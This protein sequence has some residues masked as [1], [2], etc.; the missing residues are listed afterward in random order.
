MKFTVGSKRAVRSGVVAC[1]LARGASVLAAAPA[2]AVCTNPYLSVNTA[3]QGSAKVSGNC[4]GTSQIRVRKDW[5]YTD[6]TNSTVGTTRG[7]FINRASQ[8]STVYLPSGRF[9]KVNLIET[10]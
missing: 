10:A 3:A 9:H 5:Y 4:T 2:Q 7:P 6:S 1:V 8:A